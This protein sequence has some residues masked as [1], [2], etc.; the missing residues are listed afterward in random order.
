MNGQGAV[1][2]HGSRGDG[3][4]EIAS[5]I[6]QSNVEICS[7]QCEMEAMEFGGA[8]GAGKGDS[9]LDEEFFLGM[10]SGE[11]KGV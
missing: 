5:G 1:N 3:D 4:L 2:I 11:D 7:S 10:D 6:V 9:M 8:E